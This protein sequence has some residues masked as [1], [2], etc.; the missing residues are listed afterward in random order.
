MEGNAPVDNNDPVTEITGLRSPTYPPTSVAQSDAGGKP[1]GPDP[2]DDDKGSDADHDS[3]RGKDKR[4]KKHPSGSRRPREVGLGTEMMMMETGT[5]TI[6]MTVTTV[7]S[8]A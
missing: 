3:R 4:G 6:L 2:P 8:V 1:P 7:S 5:G